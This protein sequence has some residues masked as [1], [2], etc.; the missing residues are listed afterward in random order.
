LRYF[1]RLE[2][3]TASL[4][5]AAGDAP[6][7]P[8]WVAG[9]YLRA[10]ALALLGWAWVRIC[11]TPGAQGNERWLGPG[12]ALRRWVMPEFDMRLGIIE[13]EIGRRE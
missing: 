9:D 4:V 8:Y 11:N 13:Q 6:R 1:A 10:V 3:T 7:L 2:M 12:E 5:K